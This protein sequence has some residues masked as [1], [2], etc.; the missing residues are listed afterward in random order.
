MF[1]APPLPASSSPHHARPSAVGLPHAA[2]RALRPL[3]HH[4]VPSSS[5]GWTTTPSKSQNTAQKL[6]R[7]LSL[8]KR[9]LTKRRMVWSSDPVKKKILKTT[10]VMPYRFYIFF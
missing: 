4:H 3:P 8:N 10:F 1:A 2:V 7:R 5:F 9:L 6:P